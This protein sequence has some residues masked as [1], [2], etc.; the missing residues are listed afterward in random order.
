LN[1]S[2]PRVA[3]GEPAAELELWL[4][5]IG[6][7]L[8]SPTP[9]GWWTRTSRS[10]GTHS[11]FASV[12]FSFQGPRELCSGA[13][14]SSFRLRYRQEP[15]AFFSLPG[16]QARR[17]AGL[18]PA[19]ASSLLLPRAAQ[20]TA[21]HP[22]RMVEPSPRGRPHHAPGEISHLRATSPSMPPANPAVG[23]LRLHSPNSP[24]VGQ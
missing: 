23:A 3:A 9:P 10:P 7:S 1:L 24:Q 6:E 22:Q 21:T 4:L 16:P 19:P 17:P 15:G 20:S 2:S 18:H 5:E 14:Y 11:S 13:G 8:R 12:R